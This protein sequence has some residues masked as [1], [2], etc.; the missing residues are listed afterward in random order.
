MRIII[1]KEPLDSSPMK[2]SWLQNKNGWGPDR[3]YSWE[4]AVDMIYESW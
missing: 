3:K 4:P 2:K 1:D